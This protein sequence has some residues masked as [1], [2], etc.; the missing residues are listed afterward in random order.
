MK[1][2]CTRLWLIRALS[3]ESATGYSYPFPIAMC[4]SEFS[5]ISVSR[6]TVSSGPIRPSRSTRAISPWRLAPSSEEAVQPERVEPALGKTVGVLLQRRS[7]IEP[8]LPRILLVQATDVRDRLPQPLVGLLRV[9]VRVHGLG[10]RSRRRGHDRPARGHAVHDLAGLGEVRQEVAPG[11]GGVEPRER[12]RRVR[13]RER[14]TRRVLVGE[15]E[16]PP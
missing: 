9:Q 4:V 12:V 8:R 5:S 1:S 2:M 13:A 14:D 6:K 10:P 15:I 7:S 16:E 3:D 11:A